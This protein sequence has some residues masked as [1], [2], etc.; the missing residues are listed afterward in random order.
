MNHIIY[1]SSYG[2][3]LQ[4]KIL[5]EGKHNDRYQQLRHG[6][7]QQDIGDQDVDYHLIAKGLVIF[8]GEDLCVE[9]Q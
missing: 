9:Q 4:D 7:Q 2:T 5:Q 3:D 6:L 1:M 8:N